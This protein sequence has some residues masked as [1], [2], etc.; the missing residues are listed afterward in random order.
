MPLVD[1]EHVTACARAPVDRANAVAGGEQP[2][3]GELHPLALLPRDLVARVELRRDGSDDPAQRLGERVDAQ[4]LLPVDAGLPDRQA[5]PVAGAEPDVPDLVVAPAG[6]AELQL[7]RAF[8]LP[9]EPERLRARAGHHL[10]SVRDDEDELE[11]LDGHLGG[12]RQLDVQLV[13][14]ERASRAR[15]P[16]GRGSPA[17]ARAEGRAPASKRTGVRAR[18]APAGAAAS[19][20]RRK[21]AARTAYAVTRGDGVA[22]T[23]PASFG[24][25]VAVFGCRRRHASRA[26]RGRCPRPPAAA[27]RA[28][29]AASAGGRAPGRRPPSRPRA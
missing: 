8:V 12:D 14:L 17:R 2:Q 7:E 26:A 21:S 19:A 22:L 27:P 3:V 23:A 13:V 29:A 16:P 20:A 9:A 11:P 1:D 24:D 25:G 6:A 28:R 5:E 18:P 4:A 10:E 15:R